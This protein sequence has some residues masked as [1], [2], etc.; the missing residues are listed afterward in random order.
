MKNE[1]KAEVAEG[2]YLAITMAE[3]SRHHLLARLRPR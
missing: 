1:Q 3:K 2:E